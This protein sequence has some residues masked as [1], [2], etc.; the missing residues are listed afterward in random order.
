M[1][2]LAPAR[3]GGLNTPHGREAHLGRH[4]LSRRHNAGIFSAPKCPAIPL[5][6]S[7]SCGTITR[8]QTK[9][10]RGG[11]ADALDLGSSASRRGGSSPFARTSSPA[12]ASQ[13]G[14]C[15]SSSVVECH[16]AKVD[17]ASSNLV[18]R[19]NFSQSQPLVGRR[20]I[21]ARGTQ[22]RGNAPSPH[23]RV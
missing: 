23:L 15:G 10:G 12:A 3:M 17:V 2:A 1:N 19:S 4:T 21:P 7:L 22:R 8:H 18:Y 13:A 9:R 5:T 6:T 14:A 16:L 11:M 20:H